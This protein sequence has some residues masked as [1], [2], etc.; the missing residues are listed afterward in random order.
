[1]KPS[2]LLGEHTTQV[3]GECLEMNA[4]DV[5]GLRSDRVV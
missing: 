3:F 2:P 1:V 5:E 4:A